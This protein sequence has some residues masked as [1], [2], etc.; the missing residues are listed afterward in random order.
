MNEQDRK[1][2]LINT[3]NTIAE[4]YEIPPM[5]FFSESA[6]HLASYL[7]LKGDEHILDVAT[8][9]GIAAFALAKHLPCGHV[10]GID[11]SEGMLS[12]ANSKKCTLSTSNVEF[13]KMD[14]EAIDFPKNH[15]DAAVCAF[16]LFFIE[17]MQGQ[18]GQI[19]DKVKSGGNIIITSFYETTFSPLVKV[20]LDRIREYGAEASPVPW[21]HLE[22]ENK[23]ASL[24]KSAGLKGVRSCQKDI[25]YYLKDVDEWWDIIW[26]AGYRRLISQLSPDDLK[27]FKK[28]HLEEIE[29]YSSNDGIRLEISILYTTGTKE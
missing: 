17:D 1:T 14:M 10:T 9:T 24:F 12:E 25:S 29:R 4:G 7:N 21:E 26:N 18:L 11:F 13:L 6:K 16:G 28:E 15:F 2:M 19:S 20:F 8:G 22:T 27:I 3:F 23:C 5:R